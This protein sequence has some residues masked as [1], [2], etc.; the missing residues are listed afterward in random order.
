[1]LEHAAGLAAF[2]ATSL[3]PLACTLGP[4]VSAPDHAHLSSCPCLCRFGGH[5]EAEGVRQPYQVPGE[6]VQHGGWE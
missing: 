6:L 5:P 1:M 4:G 2:L 3:F